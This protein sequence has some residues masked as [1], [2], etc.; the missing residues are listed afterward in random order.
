[1]PAAK[2]SA[3]TPIGP[4]CQLESDQIQ[5][6]I[7]VLDIQIILSQQHLSVYSRLYI[8]TTRP[9]KDQPKPNMNNAV[10]YCSDIGSVGH[11]D[12]FWDHK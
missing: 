10:M 3:R 4:I 2:G 9:T 12:D 6:C 7:I 1:M 8:I 5:K 11:F